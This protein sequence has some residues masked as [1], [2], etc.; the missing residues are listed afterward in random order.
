MNRL[1]QRALSP[2][3]FWV[4]PSIGTGFPPIILWPSDREVMGFIR[5]YQ[6]GDG[7]VAGY[8]IEILSH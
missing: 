8:P 3:E 1:G 7:L 4:G 5:I 2:H 6:R